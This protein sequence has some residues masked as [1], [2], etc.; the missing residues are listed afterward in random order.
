MSP[1]LRLL[2]EGGA[3]DQVTAVLV[4]PKLLAV[5][6]NCCWAPI[7]AL[8]GA[9]DIEGVTGGGGVDDTDEP[10]PQAATH[11]DAA[12]TVARITSRSKCLMLLPPDFLLHSL[13]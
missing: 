4:A 13:L 11:M 10:P 6:V 12:E 1:A 5:E 8:L 9:T 7:T 3:T 2:P